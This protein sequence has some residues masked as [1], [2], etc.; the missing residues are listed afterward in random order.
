MIFIKD[1]MTG[2]NHKPG[3]RQDSTVQLRHEVCESESQPT[4]QIAP[5]STK[6]ANRFCDRMARK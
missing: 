6:K 5:K 4:K 1:F 2:L 3:S